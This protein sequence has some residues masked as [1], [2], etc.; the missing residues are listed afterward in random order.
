MT[1]TACARNEQ[2]RADLHTTA[3]QTQVWCR[4]FLHRPHTRCWLWLQ[5]NCDIHPQWQCNTYCA[6]QH[7]TLLSALQHS[8]MLLYLPHDAKAASRQT[9]LQHCET[10][11]TC[12]DIWC[13]HYPSCISSALG[14]EVE[15]VLQHID[16]AVSNTR[17]G[18]EIGGLVPLKPK[19]SSGVLHTP[20]LLGLLAQW[21]WF[22]SQS[23]CQECAAAGQMLCAIALA[24]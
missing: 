22:G 1:V 6:G 15:P 19:H 23:R 7:P 3:C 18:F 2:V 8:H 11:L 24:A 4:Q 10:K 13:C 12:Q 16:H 9:Q 20:H 14:I 17:C 21:P 5:A